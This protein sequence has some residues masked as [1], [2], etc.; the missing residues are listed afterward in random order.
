MQVRMDTPN[1]GTFKFQT[2]ENG[3]LVLPVE[4]LTNISLIVVRD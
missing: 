4:I 1:N 2:E 3:T